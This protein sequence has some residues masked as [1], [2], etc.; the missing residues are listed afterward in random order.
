MPDL[1]TMLYTEPLPKFW[2]KYD[3]FQKAR[4]AIRGEKFSWY[5]EMTLVSEGRQD[6]VLPLSEKNVNDVMA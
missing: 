4:R 1:I 3:I 5:P 6:V 2:C